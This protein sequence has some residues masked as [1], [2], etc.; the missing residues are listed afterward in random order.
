MS[1]GIKPYEGLPRTSRSTEKHAGGR[2]RNFQSKLGIV[3][4]KHQ[5]YVHLL[6]LLFYVS[7]WCRQQARLRL[8]GTYE[9]SYTCSGVSGGRLISGA[10]TRLLC[11]FF[12]HLSR[13]PRGMENRSHG[14]AW[15]LG[16]LIT[17]IE[18]HLCYVSPH[19]V[20]DTMLW[21][22]RHAS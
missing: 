10:L 9:H 4:G 1:G 2:G 8:E 15:Y 21:L 16:P 7:L 18:F 14:H 19:E 22:G 6:L 20:R 17:M 3:E 11:A 13:T 12:R 5:A